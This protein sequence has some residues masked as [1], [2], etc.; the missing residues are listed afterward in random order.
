M[1]RR[2]CC[3]ASA[4]SGRQLECQRLP[5][6]VEHAVEAEAPAQASQREREGVRMLAPIRAIELHAVPLDARSVQELVEG[7]RGAF[8]DDI[9]ALPERVEQLHETVD[10]GVPLE[11]RQSNQLI[12]LS[13]Q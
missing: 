11:Q 5:I 7:E 13:W 10:V 4:G 8:D 3:G 6:R 1:Q 2:Q 9:T 12:S